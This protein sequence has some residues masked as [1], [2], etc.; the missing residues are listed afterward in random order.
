MNSIPGINS[1]FDGV[2]PTLS[3]PYSPFTLPSYQTRE[4]LLDIEVYQTFLRNAIRQ[5]RSSK[6][7]KHYKE[8]LYEIGLNRSQTHGNITNE[9]ADLEMH[10][11]IL[12]IYDIAIIITEHILN[13]CG[14]ISSFDLVHELRKVHTEHKVQLVMLDI[15]SHQLYHNTDKVFLHPLM[16]V[17]K[18]WEF[19]EEYK[20]GVTP[21]I[22]RKIN[23]Y[24][25]RAIKE[26]ES[27]DDNLSELRE[28]IK[29]WSGFNGYTTNFDL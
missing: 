7:Y 11:N 28:K 9:M 4:T 17:G 10:H 20:T 27:T 12:T 22:L 15:T 24:I 1:I 23:D 6:V 8:F 19:L 18:W 21:D 3:S 2:N 25:D 16:C 29:D 5:F 13:T 26:G 14:Y